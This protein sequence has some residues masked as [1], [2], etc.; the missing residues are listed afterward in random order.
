MGI[1]RDSPIYLLLLMEEFIKK[2]AAQ[3]ED[4]PASVFTADTR[5]REL[6]EWSS[7]LGLMTIA[8]AFEEYGAQLKANDIQTSDTIADL[9]NAI[10]AKL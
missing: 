9:Y 2:F 8:M 4:T 5:F 6:D 7:L 1:F 3:F 10:Q